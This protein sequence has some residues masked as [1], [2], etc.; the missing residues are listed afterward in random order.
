MVPIAR[1]KVGHLE[2]LVHEW[3]VW[4]VGIVKWLK[5]WP[6]QPGRH[7]GAAGDVHHLIAVV[8]QQ[9]EAPIWIKVQVVIASSGE[10]SLILKNALE[11]Q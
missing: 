9:V 10:I 4:V 11:C 8:L 3:A 5:L 2:Q 6:A 7:T 1:L